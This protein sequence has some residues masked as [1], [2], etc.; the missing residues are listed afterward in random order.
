MKKGTLVSRTFAER[1]ARIGPQK[2]S[3]GNTLT[4]DLCAVFE[5]DVREL[6]QTHEHAEVA[7]VELCRNGV[8]LAEHSRKRIKVLSSAL[9]Q[10]NL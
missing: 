2:K 8:I 3:A 4:G 1:C 9:L 5:V 10:T 7:C 6:Q